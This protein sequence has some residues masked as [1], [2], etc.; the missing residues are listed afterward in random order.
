MQI[1]DLNITY[2]KTPVIKDLTL[3]FEKGK[4]YAI[5]APSGAGKTT[6]FNAIAGLISPQSGKID[7]EGER[8][9]YIFQEPRL[10]PFMS[11]L[12]NTAL[13]APT[14]SPSAAQSAAEKHLARVG[15]EAWMDAKPDQLSIGMQQR[16][17][18]ARALTNDAAILL[19]DEPT[20]ALDVGTNDVILEILR[21]EKDNKCILFCT[22]N[23]E[24]ALKLADEIYVFSSRP[25]SLLQ[26]LPKEQATPQIL[27]SLLKKPTKNLHS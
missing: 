7:L 21:E 19:C 17:N 27:E 1:K 4:I 24:N 12:E 14:H 25:M 16:V 10:F 5:L 3:T 11:I 13:F 22:H 26:K 8:V 18:I 2:D 20:S 23:L 6:L 15:L 9:G